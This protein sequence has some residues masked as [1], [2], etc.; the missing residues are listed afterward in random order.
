M[1]YE[2]VSRALAYVSCLST[3]SLFMTSM[4]IAA[5]NVGKVPPLLFCPTHTCAAGVVVADNAQF[6]GLS[7]QSQV[8]RLAIKLWSAKI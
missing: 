2:L 1:Q 3:I 5:V 4:A 6:G 7:S 8:D